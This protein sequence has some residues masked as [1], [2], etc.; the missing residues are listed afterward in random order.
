MTMEKSTSTIKT[1]AASSYIGKLCRHFVH[2]IEVEYTETTGKALFPGGT[3]LMYAK[4]GHLTFEIEARDNE[5]LQKIKGVLVRH[6]LKFAYKE[7]LTIMWHD[8]V[9]G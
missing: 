2:K 9:A 4:S 7:D 1:Q 5:G 6:L 8:E 3:C